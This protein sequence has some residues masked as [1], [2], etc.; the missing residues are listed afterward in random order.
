MSSDDDFYG[1]DNPRRSVASPVPPSAGGRGP[2][3][4]TLENNDN[5][6]NDG[7]GRKASVHR[8]A[9]TTANDVAHSDERVREVLYSDVRFLNSSETL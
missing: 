9:H 7:T 5:N 3:S 4:P 1:A 6:N 8:V 2:E